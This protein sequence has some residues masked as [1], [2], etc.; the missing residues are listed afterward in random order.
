VTVL[1]RVRA[2]DG[3]EHVEVRTRIRLAVGDRAAR[4]H[5]GLVVADLD[6]H[7]RRVIAPTLR[8]VA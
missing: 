3:S 6:R 8:R 7:L 4:A 2:A 1:T 5:L